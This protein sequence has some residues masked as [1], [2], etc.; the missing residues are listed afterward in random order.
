M[1]SIISV[2]A[3]RN[4]GETHVGR[5]LG[6]NEAR[7]TRHL[8]RRPPFARGMTKM[9]SAG[10]WVPVSGPFDFGATRRL[11]VHVRPTWSHGD[12]GRP[13]RVNRI[14]RVILDRKHPELGSSRACWGSNVSE[15]LPRRRRG[16]VGPR[17]A[18]AFDG[19]TLPA[20]DDRTEITG[21]TVDSSHLHGPLERIAGLGPTLRSLTRLIA[22]T[23]SLMRRRTPNQPGSSTALA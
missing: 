21:P 3:S 19:M 22:M 7:E 10:F 23:R 8:D 2:L 4:A 12:P 5:G 20:H 11:P 6:R 18:S 15:L 16:E 14:T 9:L 1:S 17:Y 13:A